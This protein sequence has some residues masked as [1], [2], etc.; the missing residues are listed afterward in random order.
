LT[1][2]VISLSAAGFW[3]SAQTAKSLI[4]YPWPSID[5]VNSGAGQALP[6]RR[7]AAVG[8][9]RSP[10]LSTNVANG[11][12]GPTIVGEI[13]AARVVILL[14]CPLADVRFSVPIVL[15]CC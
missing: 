14:P 12:N 8:G 1:A 15:T 13:V 2:G 3:L 4:W 7:I 11:L 5:R 10:E 9:E 6:T